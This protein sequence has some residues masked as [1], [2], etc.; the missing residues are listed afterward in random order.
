MKSIIY[1]IKHTKLQIACADNVSQIDNLKEINRPSE[2]RAMPSPRLRYFF[3]FPDSDIY[4]ASRGPPCDSTASCFIIEINAARR[5]VYIFQR[6]QIS[7]WICNPLIYNNS[8]LI[9]GADF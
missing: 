7:S 6:F 4:S 3:Y 8:S 5:L 9:L 1:H 2:N